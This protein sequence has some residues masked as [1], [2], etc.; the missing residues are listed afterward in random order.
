MPA[1]LIG[2][3]DRCCR[4]RGRFEALCRFRRR[5]QNTSKPHNASRTGIPTPKPTPNG[6]ARFFFEAAGACDA[7]APAMALLVGV[8]E[9]VKPGVLDAIAEA[10]SVVLVDG[11]G[12]V[13]GTELVLE[14]DCRITLKS[15][16]FTIQPSQIASSPLTSS[17]WNER[18]KLA[19]SMAAASHVAEVFAD[20]KSPMVLLTLRRLEN[21]NCCTLTCDNMLRIRP[22]VERALVDFQSGGDKLGRPSY[23]HLVA[24]VIL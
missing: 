11:A 1:W 10:V 22:I 2:G 17:K 12:L 24:Q 7:A 21:D 3:V 18:V 5:R 13:D 14:A 4:P 16:L 20:E 8:G 9:A 15:I 23:S 19:P 6:T